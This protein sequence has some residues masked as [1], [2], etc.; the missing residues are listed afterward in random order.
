MPCGC[1]ILFLSLN[2]VI[3]CNEGPEGPVATH[4]VMGGNECPPLVLFLAMGYA[5]A[6]ILLITLV[7]LKRLAFLPKD[8]TPFRRYQAYVGRLHQ[9]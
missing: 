8:P 6:S 1:N 9:V 5:A 3:E 4:E 2:L 7:L